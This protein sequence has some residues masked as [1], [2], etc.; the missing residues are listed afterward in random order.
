MPY[1]CCRRLRA[2]CFTA[3]ICRAPLCCPRDA[4][5]TLLPPACPHPALQHKSLINKQG[6]KEG[7]PLLPPL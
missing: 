7:F 4:Q 6:K 1:C 5:L 3:C 2:G